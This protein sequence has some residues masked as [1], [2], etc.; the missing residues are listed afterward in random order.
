MRNSSSTCWCFFRVHG[1]ALRSNTRCFGRFCLILLAVLAALFFLKLLFAL[2]DNCRGHTYPVLVG[3]ARREHSRP[4]DSFSSMLF[5]APDLGGFLVLPISLLLCSVGVRRR[6]C[7]VRFF[8]LSERE[9]EFTHS[10]LAVLVM[11]CVGKE[12]FKFIRG[13]DLASFP[14]ELAK[15][16]I[17]SVCGHAGKFRTSPPCDCEVRRG[18]GY[19]FVRRGR[20]ARAAE[21][22]GLACCSQVTG[23]GGVE[24][25]SQR[26]AVEALSRGS[27]SETK[28]KQ[29]RVV[30]VSFVPEAMSVAP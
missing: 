10:V 25:G 19:F 6:G 21:L 29:R 17:S 24:S 9:L 1:L 18:P 30:S 20:A 16:Q 12:T 13:G 27:Q 4:P 15:C 3:L 22:R 28:V 11:S 5:R 26:T 14:L 2:P 8:A 23:T 7:A